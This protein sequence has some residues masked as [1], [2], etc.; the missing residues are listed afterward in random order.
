MFP[1]TFPHEWLLTE[2]LDTRRKD[3]SYTIIQWL[4]FGFIDQWF[5]DHVFFAFSSSMCPEKSTPCSELLGR[6]T[7][8]AHGND[9]QLTPFL[10]VLSVLL[11]S[12]IIFHLAKLQDQR[13]MEAMKREES[14][15]SSQ[16]FKFSQKMMIGRAS[17]CTERQPRH[18]YGF[19]NH[20]KNGCA[21]L[22]RVNSSI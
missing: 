4:F 17:T 8:I 16:A 7:I 19:I 20:G 6:Q 3:T 22:R 5:Y 15:S 18:K 13:K 2:P 11:H 14:T 1:S 21:L 12:R 10:V 9:K